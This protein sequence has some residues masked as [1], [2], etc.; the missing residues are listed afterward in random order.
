MTSLTGDKKTVMIFAGG[1]GGHVFPAL[2]VAKRL[3]EQ[4]YP[5]CW[6]GTKERLEAQLVPRAG[7]EFI[8][9]Q[10]QGL[11]GRGV[12][13]YIKAPFVL[14]RAV[15]QSWRLLRKYR[16]GL[17]LGFGGY[18]AGPGGVAAKLAGVPL[19]VH[20]QNAVPGLTNKLLA[21]LAKRVLVGFE[22]ARKVLRKAVWVG[23]PVREDVFTRNAEVT[24]GVTNNQGELRILVVGGSLGAQVLN[25]RVPQA[26]QR[27]RGMPLRVTH[28]A[29]RGKQT[30]AEAYYEQ[31]PATVRAEVC[32]F[33]DDM[34]SAYATHDLVIC[35]A[36]ALTVAEV[37]A[38]GIAS[39]LVPYPYAVDDHQTRNAEVLVMH[40]AAILMA[41]QKMTVEHLMSTLEELLAVPEKLEQ[42]ALAARSVAQPQATDKIVQHCLQVMNKQVAV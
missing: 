29:G 2:A 14:S 42:M 34:A 12:A 20:E 32:E 30:N 15:W 3:A 19:I 37:A 17:A 41:Q 9:L 10:Q 27:W 28:Q 31:C 11:R 6:V 39:V 16:A 23:N 8:G 35:R 18:T 7:I 13:G 38:A 40:H 24:R 21:P 22:V 5:L 4:G 36:G 33:I 26:L 25:E 1:T